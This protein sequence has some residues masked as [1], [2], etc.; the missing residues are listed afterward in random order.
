MELVARHQ[1]REERVRLERTASG[2]LVTV[3]GVAY[4]VDVARAGA[5]VH[6]LLVNGDQHA[7]TVRRQQEG[8]YRVTGARGA[9]VVELMD[10]LTHLA[11]ST[12]EAVGGR[13]PQQ[14]T[15]YM[16]GRVV[17]ILVREG[18][19]VGAGQG[20]LVLEAMKMKNE[21]QA[22]SS[23]VIEKILVERDQA[24]EGGD[25]LFEIS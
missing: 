11:R 22:E 2:Y 14:V 6:S 21:I 9:S 25:A 17:E 19:A 24:V 7:V 15:A 23:G 1:E 3:G 13:G 10:P 8:F 16:P 4:E 12:H 5:I 20:I 18:E